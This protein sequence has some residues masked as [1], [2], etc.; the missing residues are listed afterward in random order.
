[1]HSNKTPFASVENE[2]DSPFMEIPVVKCTAVAGRGQCEPV[3][4]EQHLRV[5]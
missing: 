4:I 3:E 1:M 5:S 2:N